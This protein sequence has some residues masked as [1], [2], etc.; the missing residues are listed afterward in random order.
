MR[1]EAAALGVGGLQI[2]FAR[3]DNGGEEGVVGARENQAA[4][5]DADAGG[6]SGRSG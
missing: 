3:V 2:A 6:Q 5:L 4:G 1:S